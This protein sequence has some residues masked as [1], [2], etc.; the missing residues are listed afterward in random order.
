MRMR[1]ELI[2]VLA[3]ACGAEPDFRDPEL[4]KFVD[5]LIVRGVRV[6]KKG[7][8]IR[9][10]SR[11]TCSECGWFYFS[12]KADYRGCPKCLAEMEE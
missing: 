10:R 3:S 11:N 6:R 12:I 2:E 5:E 9:E 1:N 7:K 4:I 8:W